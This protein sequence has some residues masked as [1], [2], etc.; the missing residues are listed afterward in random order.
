MTNRTSSND[1]LQTNLIGRDTVSFTILLTVPS[2]RDRRSGL[3]GLVVNLWSAT[4]NGSTKELD[5]PKSTRA[6]T[7]PR[8][9]LED[10]SITRAL[11]SGSDAA[12]NLGPCSL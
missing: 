6:L 7:V 11:G 9:T 2:I 4:K 12:L 10:S 1:E 5:D 8:N 3:I